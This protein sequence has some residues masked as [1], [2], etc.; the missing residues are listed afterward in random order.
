VPKPVQLFVV[1]L[2]TTMKSLRLYPTGSNIPRRGAVDALEAL[3]T[4]T[5]EDS[6]LELS[7]GRDGLHYQAT[8]VFPRSESFTTFAREFYK[9]NLAAVRFHEGVTPEEILL[10]LSLIIQPAE[11]VAANGG[12]EAG[13]S[14]LGVINITVAEAATRIVE[15]ALP[16]TLPTHDEDEEEEEEARQPEAQFDEDEQKSIEQILEE[17]GADQARDRR[18]LMRALRDKRA[19]AEYLREARERGSGE[20]IRDL[21]K[22]IG[23]LARSTR[24]EM[25]EDRAAVLSVIAEAIV[26]LT[27]QERG[28]LY[29]DHLIDQARRD[30]A[31]AEL[32]D[33][34][35]VDELV[36]RILGQIEETPEALTGLSRAVRN[37]TVMNVQAPGQSVLNLVVSK[38]QAQGANE[39]FISG[40]T[41]AVAPMRISGIEQFKTDRSE[42]VGTVLRLIDMTPDGS[43]VFVFDEAIEPLRAEATRGTTD[44]DVVECLVAVAMIEKRDEPFS[45]V[46]TM[47]EESVGYLIEAQEADVAADVAEA[48]AAA[49]NDESVPES[50]RTRMRNVL[51]NIANPATLAAVTNVLRRYKSDSPEYLACR[52]LITVLGEAVIEPLLE[53]LANENDMNARKA[54][55]E[56]ISISA[57]NY[58]A[59][60][61]ARVTD[62]RWYFVRNVVSIL[63]STR[64]P[65]AL[66]YLQ[67]TVRHNDARV[68]RETIRALAAI[69]SAMSDSMLATALDDEDT[70]NVEIAANYLG[71]LGSVPAVPAL[72][73]V[74]RAQSRGSHEQS[75][76]V[77]AIQALAR[78]GDPSSEQVFRDLSRRRWFDF[79]FGGGRDKAVRDAAAEA[80]R[81]MQSG[82]VETGGAA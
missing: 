49:S 13:L 59:Q 18:L 61:G 37:L 40:M 53:V 35:G 21:A 31:L 25:K 62:N 20:A 5:G 64:S 28:E 9:R 65:D 15:T 70:Q 1:R 38:M 51:V 67:R 10:F 81:T 82:P 56:M 32:I 2:S 47:V 52:R 80:L 48:M 16:G 74:A 60:L 22:R 26:E 75:A 78:I 72:E 24:H 11:Q 7:V 3:G 55:I 63:A 45:A 8:S 12:M 71:S 73:L 29:Q 54:L 14:E 69:R 6:Y 41:Q 17:A 50:H 39:S 23:A 46:M 36:D 57:K 79:L 76:R 19:V 27:P 44:G 4:A 66:A 43:D 68:R 34:L 77:E 30:Q 58:I 42:S 33:K